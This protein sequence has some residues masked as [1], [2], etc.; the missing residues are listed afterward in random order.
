LKLII[1]IIHNLGQTDYANQCLHS[2]W[3]TAEAI[4]IP[5]PGKNLGEVESYRPISLLPIMSKLF[6]KLIIKR[7]KPII[8]DKHLVP[9]HQFGFRKITRQ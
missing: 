8:A 6:K 7:L 2:A 1:Q 5:K 3:K 4:M 9:T